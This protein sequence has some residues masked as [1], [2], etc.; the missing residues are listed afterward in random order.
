VCVCVCVCLCARK[1]LELRDLCLF[2][3]H[4][5][6]LAIPQ[7]A[8][9]LIIFEIVLFFPGSVWT[10]ISLTL[11]VVAGVTDKCQHAQFSVEMD[12]S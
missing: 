3:R 7:D 2:G 12:V 10:M 8:F 11:L 6:T 9:A 1:G 5:T 4:L